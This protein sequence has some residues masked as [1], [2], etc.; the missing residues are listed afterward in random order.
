VRQRKVSE[1]E[2]DLRA[3]TDGVGDETHLCSAPI[4]VQHPSAARSHT[5]CPSGP[6]QFK[7][8]HVLLASIQAVT[9]AVGLHSSSDHVLSLSIQ[10]VTHAVAL[11]S[12]SD[13]WCWH[14]F[15]QLLSIQ[16]V[17]RAVG[18]NSTDAGPVREDPDALPRRRLHH[19]AG[20]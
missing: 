4:L 1:G 2:G 17:T 13:P 19:G 10:A 16:A 15:K 11:N 18:L 14:Q 3:I 20:A 7:Q 12:S 6:S 9:H 8:W 5:P